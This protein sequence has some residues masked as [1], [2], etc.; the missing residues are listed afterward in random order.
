[1]IAELDLLSKELQKQPRNP[2]LLRN[3]GKYYLINGYYKQAR[4]E[5]NLAKLFSPQIISEIILDHEELA[6]SKPFDT[7]VRLS[8]I[9][10]YLADNDLDMA[11][12]ELEELIE[13]DPLNLQAY[14]LLG[15]IY[16]KQEKIDFAMNL[17]EKA[18]K[19]GVKDISISEMLASV[20]LEKGRLEDAIEFYEDLPSDK[21]NLRMLAEL[22]QRTENYEKSAEKYF[23]MYEDDPEVSSEVIHRLEA[24]LLK[25]IDSISIRELLS[26]TYCKSL[27][28]ESAI[29]KLM[30]IIKIDPNKA[31][32]VIS[33][34]KDILK[35]YPIHPEATLSL[36]EVLSLK[37]NYSEAIEEYYKLIK[38]N[39]DYQTK[40]VE[41]VK[42]IIKKYPNQFLARQFLIENYLKDDNFV[43]ASKEI[44][45]LLDIYPDSAE[46]VINKSKGLIKQSN[47]MRECLGYVYLS[48][49]D[50]FSANVEVEKILK[51]NNQNSQALI[52]QA[53]IF[54]RQKLCSKA[55]ESLHKA[56]KISPYD[57]TIHEK[58]KQARLKEIELETEQL[59]KRIAEDEWK[60]SLHLD[61]GKL[62]I[63][64]EMK[65][66]A[67]RELQAASKDT[68]K[69][70]YV[71]SLLGNFY[72]YEGLYDQSAD[73]F[74]K[75]L[76][77]ISEESTDLQKKT[78]FGLALTYEA[79]GN[80]RSAIRTL[81]EIQQEDI[82]Y[83]Y[84]KYKMQFLRKTSLGALQN[85]S[86]V[87]IIKDLGKMDFLGMWGQ[88][89]KRGISKQALSVSFGQN[90]NNSGLEFFMKG[91]SSTAEEEFALA[92]QLDPNYVAGLNNLAITQI[93][94]KKNS[95][96]LNN[97]RKAFEL[98][99]ASPIVLNNLGLILFLNN[100]H[101]E[102]NYILKK[103]LELNPNLP[104][105]KLNLADLFY[106]TGKVKEALDLYK[107]VEQSE[108]TYEI[109][110]KRLLYKIP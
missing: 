40:A 27:R 93:I 57:T 78:R 42:T 25:K 1:M 63:E 95:E 50:F 47:E 106:K 32:D 64:L 21:K 110:Q 20:Y 10:F 23:L 107:E 53:E 55:R 65:E 14:N 86:F 2:E 71:Y 102:A 30:E 67:I 101:N 49:N 58:Y 37:E 24:L 96:A 17:L 83:P 54:L 77:F 51:L 6:T 8:L 85:K 7:Q 36:A 84:V 81:E 90:Y 33:K 103:A 76:Q 109:A 41:G 4:E 60:L 75:S 44:K 15:K 68:Q 98:E 87:L 12:L 59:K 18:L 62:Y 38:S 26:I 19:L 22:Y 43:E 70:A 45:S 99:P 16:I 31:D 56:L 3:L 73:A 46:W 91:M 11:I 97:L 105:V 5:Y 100:S 29:K 13:L 74:K 9:S 82:D 108:I 89:L 28:P 79:Q 69:A 104:A 48:K 72:R 88:E 34:L 94:N 80:I 61:L 66:D 92:V 52:L 39:P 35:N